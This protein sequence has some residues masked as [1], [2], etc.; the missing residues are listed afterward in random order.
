MF[1]KILFSAINSGNISVIKAKNP[2]IFAFFNET[3]P[4][5]LLL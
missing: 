1:F 5:E 2:T 4:E 3:N